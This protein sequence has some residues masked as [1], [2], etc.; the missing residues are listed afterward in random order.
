[1]DHVANRIV[2][3]SFD[4]CYL[5]I[6]INLTII[7]TVLYLYYYYIFPNSVFS[8]FVDAKES[9]IAPS[10]KAGRCPWYSDAF[11]MEYNIMP[12]RHLM[13]STRHFLYFHC[14][15]TLLCGG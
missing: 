3:F 4:V 8:G 6:N 13:Y 1:M 15:V 5:V 14:K 9:P 12:S 7:H 2:K 11:R 10:V